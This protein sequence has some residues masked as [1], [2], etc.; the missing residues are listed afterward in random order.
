MT[1]NGPQFTSHEFRSCTRNWEIQHHTSSPGYAK[2]NGKA[3]NSVKTAKQLMRKAIKAKAD[4]YLAMLDFGN[5][6]TQETNTSP[7]QRLMSR[8]TRTLLPTTTQLLKPNVTDDYKQ[9]EA[10]KRQQ[11]YYYDKKAKGK[12][13]LQTNDTVRIQPLRGTDEWE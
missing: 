4:P 9:L 12:Q 1:V 3:E 13:Q 2:S 7:A 10:A 8:R 11:A 5:T 6:P